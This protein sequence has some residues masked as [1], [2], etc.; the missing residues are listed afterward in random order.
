MG[1]SRFSGLQKLVALSLITLIAIFAAAKFAHGDASGTST[2]T[3]ADA[4]L[5]SGNGG[6]GFTDPNCALNA[7]TPPTDTGAAVQ[8]CAK[9]DPGALAT[10]IGHNKIAINFADGRASRSSSAAATS[11]CARINGPYASPPT[12]S[13]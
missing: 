10:Q 4:A 2:G 7:S 13:R 1:G 9:A 3:A 12:R 8:S 6:T 5:F 11:S